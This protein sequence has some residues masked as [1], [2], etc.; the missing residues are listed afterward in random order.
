MFTFPLTTQRPS[1]AEQPTD[2]FEMQASTRD[3]IINNIHLFIRLL[4]ESKSSKKEDDSKK[5]IDENIKAVN[6][7]NQLGDGRHEFQGI[8]R[9]KKERNGDLSG[10]SDESNE[11][12]VLLLSSHDKDALIELLIGNQGY[13]YVF[14]SEAQEAPAFNDELKT[15]LELLKMN[16]APDYQMKIKIM[17]PG[18]DDVNSEPDGGNLDVVK[19]Q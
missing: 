13:V 11:T 6:L 18:D 12:Q 15:I 5:R 7:L 8:K 16:R 19:L 1:S 4:N 10:Q 14:C 3:L 17:N 2:I 9:V